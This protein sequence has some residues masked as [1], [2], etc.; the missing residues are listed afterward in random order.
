MINE[1]INFSTARL[2]AERRRILNLE[3][4]GFSSVQTN[5]DRQVHSL[6]DVSPFLHV[7]HEGDIPGM[8]SGIGSGMASGIGFVGGIWPSRDQ[9]WA[10]GTE[11]MVL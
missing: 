1:M 5:V 11:T 9:P 8:D 7:V 3:L 6:Y 10:L 4:L 2:H